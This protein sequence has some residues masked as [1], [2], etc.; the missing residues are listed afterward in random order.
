ML[1]IERL[2]SDVQKLP[3]DQQQ[4]VMDF[5]EFLLSRIEQSSA[6]QEESEW[7]QASI[8][9][10]MQRMDEEEGEDAP[11]YTLSDVNVRYK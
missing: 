11:V 5:V 6:R 7:S 1:S 4:E 2:Q 8:S 10:M 3:V 9:Y